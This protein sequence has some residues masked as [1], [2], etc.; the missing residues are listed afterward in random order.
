MKPG[1]D[2]LADKNNNVQYMDSFLFEAD[3]TDKHTYNAEIGRLKSS[4]IKYAQSIFAERLRLQRSE[5]DRLINEGIACRVVYSGG[6]SYHIK[7]RIK[8]APSTLA[9]YKWLHAYLCSGI[10]S[11]RL[12]FDP[13][14]NDPARLTRAPVERDRVFMYQGYEIHG[15]Q[16]LY[17]EAEDNVFDYNWRA[18]YQ[19]WLDRAP[20]P[21]ET[22]GKKLRP[23]KQEY[24]DAMWALLNGTFWT[25]RMWHG[26]RQTCFF[27]AYR[28]CRL[29]G[30]SHDQLWARD[31]ILDG[32]QKYYKHS[33]IEYWR[34][35]EK[36]ALIEQIDSEVTAQLEED[37]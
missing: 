37:L 6:K 2:S 23:V 27:P 12:D 14:C 33:E 20:E 30:Y 15:I 36:C 18:A 8:D 3:D 24:R 10:I 5:A 28:L 35:R 34:N 29:L 16:A 17:R 1:V 7:V 13:Q 22:N 32:L 9:E 31:G 26:R 19:E 25:D 4:N 11:N 21:Y